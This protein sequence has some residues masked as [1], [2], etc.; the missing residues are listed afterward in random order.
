MLPECISKPLSDTT[1]QCVKHHSVWLHWSNILF[2][3]V[4]VIYENHLLETNVIGFSSFS[5]TTIMWISLNR[6][7]KLWP[8]DNVTLIWSPQLTKFYKVPQ[9]CN[10]IQYKI[11]Q[12]TF[13]SLKIFY[14]KSNPSYSASV[15]LICKIMR[16]I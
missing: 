15:A 2:G 9:N 10:I 13:K 11:Q 6:G 12:Q 8:I 3:M 1:H 4:T 7:F 16:R 5:C 14:S